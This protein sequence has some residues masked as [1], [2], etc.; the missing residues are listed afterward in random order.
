ML[1]DDLNE[2]KYYRFN[3]LYNDYN[4]IKRVISQHTS[5]IS[6]D[7]GQGSELSSYLNWI[8]L[9]T[10]QQ[11][12]NIE[13]AASG[14][15]AAKSVADA[16]RSNLNKAGQQGEVDVA[17]SRLGGRG[18]RRTQSHTQ[19]TAHHTRPPRTGSHNLASHTHRSLDENKIH[20]LCAMQIGRRRDIIA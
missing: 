8:A 16:I 4:L 20:S 19:P 6:S 17:D 3:V 13:Q 10:W 11:A 2:N 5:K 1:K 12:R 7:V 14:T 9:A 15:A 18:T